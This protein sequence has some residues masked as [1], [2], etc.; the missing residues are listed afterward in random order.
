MA[1]NVVRKNISSIKGFRTN[2]RQIHTF[3]NAPTGLNTTVLIGTTCT[4]LVAWQAWRKYRKNENFL[5][6]VYAAQ[7]EKGE[8]FIS[9]YGFHHFLYLDI[10][11]FLSFVKFLA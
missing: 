10:T 3:K 6:K 1:T 5:P 8:V 9:S 4:C 7:V 11:L 2:L